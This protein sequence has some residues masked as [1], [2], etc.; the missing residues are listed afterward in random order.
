MLHVSAKIRPA[1]ISDPFSGSTEVDT[2][3]GKGDVAPLMAAAA[4]RRVAMTAPQLRTSLGHPSPDAI[5]ADYRA[6]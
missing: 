4:H 3:A 2:I 1:Y 6:V 5:G